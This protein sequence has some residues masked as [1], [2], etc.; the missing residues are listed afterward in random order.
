MLVGIKD[1]LF[2]FKKTVVELMRGLL[3][4][5]TRERAFGCPHSLESPLGEGYQASLFRP[6]THGIVVFWAGAHFMRGEGFFL[7]DR[8]HKMR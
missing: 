2:S 6:L 3:C 1:I 4:K 7:C 8:D 5:E